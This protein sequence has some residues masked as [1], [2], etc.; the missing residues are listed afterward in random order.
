MIL[1][2]VKATMAMEGLKLT[3][4]EEKVLQDYACGKISFDDLKLF[5]TEALKESKAA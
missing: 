1:D 3:A 2:E 4:T 5:L